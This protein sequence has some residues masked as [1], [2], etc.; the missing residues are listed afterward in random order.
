MPHLPYIDAVV[1]ALD[2]AGLHPAQVNAGATDEPTRGLFAHLA[3][4][5]DE[6]ALSLRWS[7]LTDWRFESSEGGGPL[8]ISA[9]ASPPAVVD[10]VRLLLTCR[11][12]VASEDRWDRAAELEV[13]L[14]RW[15]GLS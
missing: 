7:S 10:C 3:W 15:E 14:Y 13:A 1:A 11:P 5:S 2:E 4:T 9:V 12:A 8:L 6:D